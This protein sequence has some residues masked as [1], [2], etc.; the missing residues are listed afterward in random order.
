MKGGEE[1]GGER[2][3]QRVVGPRVGALQQQLSLLAQLLC[4]ELQSPDGGPE[5][6]QSLKLPCLRHEFQDVL[7]NCPALVPDHCLPWVESDPGD[8]FQ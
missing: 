7:W 1:R 5:N 2:C 6:F 4:D 8:A 3:T